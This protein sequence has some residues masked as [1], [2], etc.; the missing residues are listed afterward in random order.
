MW[1]PAGGVSG[2]KESRGRM[3][4]V[5]FSGTGN[6][7]HVLEVFL[8]AYDEESKSFSIEDDGVFAAVKEQ[9]ELA[10]AYPVQYS[11]V[12]KILSDFI[13][14]NKELW[15]GK[16]VF[17]IATMG[18]FS[19]DG[20]GAMARLLQIYGAEVLGGV[21]IKMPDSIG[22]EKVLKRSLEKNKELVKRGEEKVRK[23]VIRL[24]DGKP[25]KEGLGPF[26]RM[27]GFFGQ[28][29]YFGNKTKI[30]S[31]KLKIDTDKC[32]G[33]GKCVTLCPM[34][35]IMIKDGICV[36]EDRCTMCYRCVNT[37]PKQAITLLGKE[38]VEQSI[39]EKYL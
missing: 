23:A 35:N 25:T 4:G 20:A 38:V 11:T 8:K 37:C 34:K 2:E 39:I 9:E 12:P 33:C 15:D 3:V 27:L 6:S 13:C 22:D 21:H 32:V 26:S 10:F 1:T 18:L 17:V 31:D 24:K 5:Y 7:R 28:R 16:R 30:Y 19:G 14:E 29:L 36:S